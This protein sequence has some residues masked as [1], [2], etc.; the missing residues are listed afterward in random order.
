MMTKKSKKNAAAAA[1]AVK[2][3]TALE[4]TTQE[5]EALLKVLLISQVI[6]TENV[7][8]FVVMLGF[9]RRWVT[10]KKVKT[11]AEGEL[12][13]VPSHHHHPVLHRPRRRRKLPNPL[14]LVS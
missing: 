8:I 4:R 7:F 2:K 10:R 6:I 13:Q 14:L 11:R 5:G 9:C 12:A 1:A 3:L